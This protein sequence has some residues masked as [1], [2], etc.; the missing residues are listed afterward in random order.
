LLLVGCKC[1]AITAVLLAL[2]L[3]LYDLL[4]GTGKGQAV[5]LSPSLF[6]RARTDAA[7]T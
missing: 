5:R 1:L 6:A 3:M 4:V 2:G 7:L